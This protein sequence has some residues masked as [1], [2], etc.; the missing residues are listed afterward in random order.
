LPVMGSVCAPY[1]LPQMSMTLLLAVSPGACEPPYSRLAATTY[2]GRMQLE[3]CVTNGLTTIQSGWFAA[4]VR[5]MR[6]TDFDPFARAVSSQPPAKLNRKPG[7]GSQLDS[8]SAPFTWASKL[9]LIDVRSTMR[10][11]W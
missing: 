6:S 10:D 1:V 4:S 2:L 7:A 8:I 9:S 3:V 11:I 5:S